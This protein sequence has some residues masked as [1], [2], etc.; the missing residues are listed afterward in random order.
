VRISPKE[1][2][3]MFNPAIRLRCFMRI[4]RWRRIHVSGETGRECRDCGERMFDN[5]G[6][7]RMSPD[8]VAGMLGGMG[9]MGGG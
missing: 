3:R 2:E 4:H 9:G 5:P 6:G 7:P 1:V 8:Q